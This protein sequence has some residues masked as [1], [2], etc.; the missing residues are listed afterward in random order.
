MGL[1]MSWAKE[2]LDAEREFKRLRKLY[3]KALEGQ[4]SHNARKIVY[5][6]ILLIQLRNGSRISEA[7][8]ALLK[9]LEEG[10]REVFVMVR[11]RKREVEH[12][13]MIIPQ[14]IAKSHFE[15]DVEVYKLIEE[16]GEN[17]REDP[18]RIKKVVERIS[19]WCRRHLGYSTHALRHAFIT[20]YTKQGV[21]PQ[22]LAK[23]TKHKR[24]DHII[25]YTYESIGEELLK[26][27]F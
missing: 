26:R 21:A 19:N 27:G 16:I 22:V 23:I 10:K 9:F 15:K 13:K 3:K 12:R 6:A 1:S 7:I 11:K 14:E 8:E 24:I 2:T 4:G 18:K 17:F 5:L 20:Y 25:T